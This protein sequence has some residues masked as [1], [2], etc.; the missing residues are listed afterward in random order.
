[1]TDLILSPE[2]QLAQLTDFDLMPAGLETLEPGDT[3]MPPR[4]RISQ[5]NRPIEIGGEEAQPGMIVNTLTGEYSETI[6]IVPIVFLPKTRV[7]WPVMYSADSTPECVSD[8]GLKPTPRADTTNP[9]PGPCVT[10]PMAE[11]VNG[12]KPRCTLQ[13]NFLV[14]VVET[15]EAAILTMQ[16]TAL[17]EAR[18]LTT[19]AKTA[20]LKRT[21]KM[22]TLKVK[23]DRGSWYVPRFSRGDN[24]P[25]EEI[26]NLVQVRNELKNLVISADIVEDTAVSEPEDDEVPF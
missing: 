23:D 5:P 7:M 1:M 22:T 13:R 20:G 6:N 25:A 3:G 16:S 19:L 12:Q 18:Q 24:L 21:I 8:T 17:K 2:Q 15:G 9:Q 4:L 14:W 10:C 11:F 26:V